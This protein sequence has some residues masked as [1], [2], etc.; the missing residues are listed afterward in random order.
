MTE[1]RPRFPLNPPETRRMAIEI[2]IPRLGWNMDEGV[3][4][5]WLKKDG[6]SVRAGDPL[7]SL[8]GEKAT[9]DVEAI[10]EGVLHIPPGAPSAGETVAVGAV[11]GYLVG[12]GDSAPVGVGAA[13]AAVAGRVEANND[14]PPD[15]RPAPDGRRQADRPR[16]SP[17]ARRLAREFGVDW[18]RLR[19]SGRTGRVRK[20]DVLAAVQNRHAETRP[21]PAPNGQGVPVTATRRAIAA[22]MVESRQ[23]TAPV[24]L[25]TTVDASNLVNLRGQFKAADPSGRDVPGVTDFLVKLSALALRDHPLLHAR[26]ADDRLVVPEDAHI[27]LAVDTEAGLIVPV[28]H[29]AAG[30]GLRQLAARS[31]ELIRRAR[32]GGL[33]T[34]DLQGGTFT[35]SNLGAFGVEAFTPI[36]N[37]PECAVLGVGRIERKPVMDGDKVVGREQMV[38]SL[39]FDH[40]VVDGAPAARFL[41]HLGRM[42]ENPGPWLLA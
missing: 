38:L 34:G 14:P 15:S 40:R 6:E 23:T 16:S 4:V 35:V 11:I 25:T 22:R 7:F 18:T 5:G 12:P 39:T 17:L 13:T 31:R 24:T 26:W 10:D 2:T 8:E 42:I 1:G 9:Q 36:I 27:G 20:A 41:Q 28:I 29:G 19:G 33:R 3:F 21:S 37:P 30:L 32:E